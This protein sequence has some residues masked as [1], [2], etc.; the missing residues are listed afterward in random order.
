VTHDGHG[1]VGSALTSNYLVLLS[2]VCMDAN[3]FNNYLIFVAACGFRDASFFW[4]EFAS[5]V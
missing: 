5:K 3:N 2:T 4:C 1:L